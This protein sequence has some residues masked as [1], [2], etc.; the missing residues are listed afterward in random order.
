LVAVVLLS[1]VLAAASAARVAWRSA[2][3]AAT[4]AEVWIVSTAGYPIASSCD[5]SLGVATIVALTNPGCD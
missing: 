3:R 5:F 2:R 1:A 4:S